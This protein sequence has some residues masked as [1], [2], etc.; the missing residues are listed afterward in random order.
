ME[1]VWE[2]LQK[3]L[4]TMEESESD[5]LLDL[6]NNLIDPYEAND[7]LGDILFGDYYT[8]NTRISNIKYPDQIK[9]VTGLEEHGVIEVTK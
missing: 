7:D 6:F 9:Y 5:V 4:E 3:N 1:A 2:E 8:F